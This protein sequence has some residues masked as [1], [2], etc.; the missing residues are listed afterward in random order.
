MLFH[1]GPEKPHKGNIQT[2]NSTGGMKRGTFIIPAH[3]Y[4]IIFFLIVFLAVIAFVS[5]GFF[6]YEGARVFTE[7]ENI[8]EGSGAKADELAT[9][10]ITKVPEGMALIPAGEFM[11]GSPMDEGEN[12]EHPP[13]KVHIDAFFMDKYEVTNAQFKK[14]VDAT[15]YVT[16]AEKNG[17]SWTWDGKRWVELEGADWRHP[18]GPRSTLDDLMNYPVV[19]LSWNDAE[20]YAKWAGKRLPTEA[21]WEKACRGGTTS[22]YS[23]G[24][25]ITHEDANFKG[26][27]GR[28]VWQ[29]AS[30]VGSFAPNQWGLYDMYGNVWERCSDWYSEN[31]YAESPAHMP[32]GPEEGDLRVL[33]GGSWYNYAYALRSPNRYVYGETITAHSVGFR[34]AK[35]LF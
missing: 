18:A 11:M 22:R 20:A 30:P 7:A 33:R 5:G 10:E 3:K 6:L 4:P 16:Q 31:Y 34:C 12:D 25:K 14:F 28:D 17:K 26:V 35:D 23:T 19:H 24:E 21:E 27:G 9:Q 1:A 13:H 32:Q 29:Q 2:T 8:S 15:N